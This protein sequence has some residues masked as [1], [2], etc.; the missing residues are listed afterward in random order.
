LGDPCLFFGPPPMSWPPSNLESFRPTPAAWLGKLRPTA[1]SSF[2]FF[3]RRLACGLRGLRREFAG[4]R[5]RRA[6]QWEP[7]LATYLS[8]SPSRPQPPLLHDV[9]STASRHAGERP[10]ETCLSQGSEARREGRD[11]R[12]RAEA[13]GAR[14]A[15]LSDVYCASSTW[16]RARRLGRRAVCRRISSQPRRRWFVALRSGRGPRVP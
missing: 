15:P 2:V 3:S 1:R 14:D 5:R 8:L 6:A 12:L 16:S 9:P 11:H 13:R 10:K 4:F 7:R